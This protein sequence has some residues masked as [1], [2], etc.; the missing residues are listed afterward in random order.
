MSFSRYD[1]DI[2]DVVTSPYGLGGDVMSKAQV[3][4]HRAV[5]YVTVS[6]TQ[7]TKVDLGELFLKQNVRILFMQ[8]TIL[9]FHPETNKGLISGHDGTR[10]QFSRSN[11]TTPKVN[12]DEGITV[13]FDIDPNDPKRAIDIVII[14]SSAPHTKTARKKSTATLWAFF[15]G[16]LGAHKFYLGD[17]GM[18]I[19]YILFVWTAIPPI[20]AFFEFIGL[21]LMNESDFNRKYNY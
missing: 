9:S 21:A 8:G 14:K 2:K 10:Y 11:W 3:Q 19:V 20:I 1:Q 5:A 18:G 4:K 17:K 6:N 15:L 12:P 13:D 7:L 16:G